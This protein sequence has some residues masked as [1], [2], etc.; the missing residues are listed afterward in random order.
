MQFPS[1]IEYIENLNLRDLGV[2][3]YFKDYLRLGLYERSGLRVKEGQLVED[4]HGYGCNEQWGI[5]DQLI[6]IDKNSKKF[7]GFRNEFIEDVFFG[8][9]KMIHKFA[10]VSFKDMR[11]LVQDILKHGNL[12]PIP[13]QVVSKKILDSKNIKITSN[14]EMWCNIEDETWWYSDDDENLFKIHPGGIIK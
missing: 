10:D 6:T 9:Y 5:Y 14:N 4:P 2:I 11:W 8:E 13:I 7:G 1:R 12:K 3:N